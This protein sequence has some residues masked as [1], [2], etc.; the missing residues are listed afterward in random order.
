MTRNRR[1]AL[2]RRDEL[3]YDQLILEF[4]PDGWVHIGF[5]QAGKVAHGEALTYVGK[6]YERVV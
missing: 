1:K 5:A 2:I 3:G 6:S 4:P